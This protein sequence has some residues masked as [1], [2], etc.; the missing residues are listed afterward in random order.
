M[1]TG[2]VLKSLLLMCLLL[3]FHI[4]ESISIPDYSSIEIKGTPLL[5]SA[6]DSI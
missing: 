1:S 3:M 5:F 2:K 6:V 4:P